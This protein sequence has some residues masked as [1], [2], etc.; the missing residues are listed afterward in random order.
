MSDWLSAK[1][2][3]FKKKNIL[4]RARPAR[5]SAEIFFLKKENVCREH[6]QTGSRQRIFLKK[7]QTLCREPA[8]WALGKEGKR[9]GPVNSAFS[10]PRAALA[11]GKASALAK[12][13][14]ADRIFAETAL[15]RAALGK[16]F[17][18]GLR[19]LPRAWALGKA[20]G[21]SSAPLRVGWHHKYFFRK[22]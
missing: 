16:G 5:L 18:E 3:F 1:S 10:L 21:S 2:F 20:A 9:W 13:G 15:P 17:A 11:L 6:G 7:R 19:G 8:R 4:P 12:K 14:F 22:I